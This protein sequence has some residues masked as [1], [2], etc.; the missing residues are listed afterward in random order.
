MS[1]I[2]LRSILILFHPHV[3]F[4]TRL[5]PSHFHTK[6]LYIFFPIR[7]TCL[8]HLILCLTT[9]IA[10]CKQRKSRISSTSNFSPVPCYL[11]PNT[12]LNTLS[13]N[14]LQLVPFRTA[15]IELPLFC[16]IHVIFC[17]INI[18][19]CYSRTEMKLPGEILGIVC[20]KP[21]GVK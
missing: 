1:C 17:W 20:F 6:T 11:L 5:F 7:A 18:V 15:A 12:Y 10:F 9:R 13:S 8:A 4:T 2:S 16:R 21:W 19:R 3:G 14:N